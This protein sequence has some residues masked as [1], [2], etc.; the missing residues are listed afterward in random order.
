MY[1]LSEEIDA[2]KQV[3][4][5]TNSQI[6][7]APVDRDD[8]LYVTDLLASVEPTSIAGA[9]RHEISVSKVDDTLILFN[10]ES[11]MVPRLIHGAEIN[12][13]KSPE[14]LNF[15]GAF[16]SCLFRYLNNTKDEYIATDMQ[17]EVIWRQPLSSFP[18][19]GSDYVEGHL[20]AIDQQ[21][22]KEGRQ[23]SL[24]CVNTKTGGSLWG[25]SFE[26][27]LSRAVSHSCQQVYWVSGS[28]LIFSM[29]SKTAN[30]L[31]ALDIKTGQELWNI[32][33][34]VGLGYNLDA[35]TGNLVGYFQRAFHVVEGTTGKTLVF[36]EFAEE[37]QLNVD[38]K[39]QL[40][41]DGK[42]FYFG[43]REDRNHLNIAHVVEYG[44]VDP[45]SGDKLWCDTFETE[46]QLGDIFVSGPYIY[47]NTPGEGYRIFEKTEMDSLDC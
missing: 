1:K 18:R 43:R 17:G 23:V 27:G 7:I 13:I 20:L 8:E 40:I 16:T 29:Q 36:N 12:E 37:E 28:R 24:H 44:V 47:L 32:S 39:S 5:V 35:A 10:T 21:R 25:H 19:Y 3:L 9:I 34:D 22:T 2:P 6:L 11:P 30:H 45:V 41:H 33:G 46:C 31:I 4:G 42:L 26:A 14:K 15:Y 38:G